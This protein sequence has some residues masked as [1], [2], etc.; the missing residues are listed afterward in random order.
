MGAR[1]VGA[2]VKRREDPRLL[3][4]RARYV[5]DFRPPGCLHAAILRSP[6]AH[7]RIRGIR[8]DRA[9]AHPAVIG[10]FGVGGGLMFLVFYSARHGHDEAVFHG[11]GWR[12]PE[13]DGG[14]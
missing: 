10:C 4:G 9:R 11:T 14:S 13:D 3:T 7:A 8:T 1:Y 6:H 12:F 2:E 5:D